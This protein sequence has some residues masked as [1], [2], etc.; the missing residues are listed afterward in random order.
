MRAAK[1]C[2]EHLWPIR[3]RAL[4]DYLFFRVHVIGRK[5]LEGNQFQTDLATFSSTYSDKRVKV[6]R[7]PRAHGKTTDNVDSILWAI[8]KDQNERILFSG[9]TEDH[10]TGV[11]SEIKTIAEKCSKLHVLFPEV[12]SPEP[13]DFHPQWNRDRITV[14]R[15]QASKNPTILAVGLESGNTGSHWTKIFLDDQV[16]NENYRS[17]VMR[18]MVWDRTLACRALLDD[19]PEKRAY[20]I[21]AN[22]PWHENDATMRLTKADCPFLDDVELFERTVYVGNAT[23]PSDD[24]IWPE[25]R[26]PEF[27]AS[28]RRAGMRFFS[29]HYLMQPMSVGEHPFDV[30]KLRPFE[31]RYQIDEA[32]IAHWTH[33]D[34]IPF[35]VHMAV[36]TNTNANTASDPVAIHIWAKD[37][38]KH[39]WGLH[40]R[41]VVGC[42]TPQLHEL[43]HEAFMLWRPQSIQ[44][45]VHGQDDRSYYELMQ[46][47]QRRGVS[48]PVNR[49]TRGGGRGKGS[50][51]GRIVPMSAAVHEGWFHVPTDPAW[52]QF[53]EEMELFDENCE[54]DDQM[55]CVADIY[56]HG[57]WPTMPQKEEEAPAISANL[58]RVFMGPNLLTQRDGQ[59]KLMVPSESRLYV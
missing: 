5:Y 4:S 43:I 44:F 56:T 17:Q 19:K 51:Y 40:K 8:T 52:R 27:I 55:D 13:W 35:F 54:H 21:Y 28:Q 45:E 22:T 37:A 1:R 11:L 32:G 33:P 46:Y 3:E 41:R 29:P 36:D 59:K 16:N 20:L 53:I 57:R 34:D 42:T 15:S 26:T 7:V 24:V 14:R 2:P 6:K 9:P 23:D 58:L 30:T 10:A 25:V 12:W 38:M 48:Y 50:K 47:G 18:D 49:L 39:M 31:L